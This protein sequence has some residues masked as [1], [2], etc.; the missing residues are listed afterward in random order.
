MMR[1]EDAMRQMLVQGPMHQADGS[2]AEQGYA[3]RA[4]KSYDLGRIKAPAGHLRELE[5]CLVLGEAAVL[6]LAILNLGGRRLGSIGL[7]DLARKERVEAHWTTREASHH[8]GLSPGAGEGTLRAGNAL[9]DLRLELRPG[10]RAVYGHIYS[11]Q[12]GGRQLLFDLELALPRQDQLMTL[13]ACP[14]RPR[15]FACQQLLTCL[16]ANGRAIWG[17]RDYLYSPASSLAMVDRRWRAWPRPARQAWGLMMGPSQ[18]GLLCLA[19]TQKVGGKAGQFQGWLF[20]RGQAEALGPLR[21]EPPGPDG[22]RARLIDQAGR[23][24]L[25]F[26][27]EWERQARAGSRFKPFVRHTNFGHFT[28]RALTRAGMTLRAECLPGLM[29]TMVL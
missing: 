25:G 29:E 12:E 9:C 8:P 15:H 17:E 5:R 1:L 11:L 4:L 27:R 3:F 24:D 16:P 2:L 26:E 6:D 20:H 22:P 7:Y 18:H 21:L 14:G 13:A 28:G 10:S 23:V 19:F